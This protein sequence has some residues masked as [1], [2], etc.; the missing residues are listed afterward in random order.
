MNGEQLDRAYE[1]RVDGWAERLQRDHYLRLGR[2][3]VLERDVNVYR[4]RTPGLGAGDADT[5]RDCVAAVLHAL[6][7]EL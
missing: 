2:G 5:A 1:E 3:S 4:W 6:T 7:D